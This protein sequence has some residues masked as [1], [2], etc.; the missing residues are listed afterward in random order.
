MSVLIYTCLLSNILVHVN[1][2]IIYNESNIKSTSKYY[3]SGLS[4]HRFSDAAAN[5][6]EYVEGLGGG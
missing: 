3:E 4:T 2:N 1:V 6:V 5:L